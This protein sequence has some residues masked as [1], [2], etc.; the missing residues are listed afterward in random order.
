[1]IVY[2]GS[3]V[4]VTQPRLVEQNRFLDF[5][6]GFYTTLSK[7]QAIAFAEKVTA[8]RGEGEKAVSIVKR[9]NHL[10]IKSKKAIQPIGSYQRK[11]AF[12][13]AV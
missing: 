11:S 5:G 7:P 3:N 12:L 13:F 4:V 9:A 8:R 2:H 1:M 10:R 6:H